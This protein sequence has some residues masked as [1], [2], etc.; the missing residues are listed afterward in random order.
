MAPTTRRQRKHI[1]IA[2]DCFLPRWDGIARFLLEIVPKLAVR[3]RITLLVP[4]F[5]GPKISLPS[6]R[7]VYIPLSSFRSGDYPVPRIEWGKI[8]NV[9][10]EA[11]LVFSQTIGPVGMLAILA[12]KQGRKPLLCYTHSV[13]WELFSNSAKYARSLIHAGTRLFCRFL[14]G[15]A[16][17]LLVPSKDT[18]AKLS[19]NG[20][21]VP[22][23]I[24]HL[25][26]NS[27]HFVPPKSKRAA[28]QAIH[29]APETILVGFSGRVAR[30]KDLP[31]LDRAFQLVKRQ[32]PR[33]RLLI[34]GKGLP[35]EKVFQSTDDIIHV[36]QTSDIQHYLQAMDVYVMPS[37]T[38]T[39]SLS[40]LEAM[41][42]GVPVIATYVGHIK[43]YI[44]H[45]KN[46]LFF[47]KQDF[48]ELAAG[49]SRL[50][51]SEKLRQEIGREGRKTVLDKYSWEKT[52]KGIVKI[53]DE[54]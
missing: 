5:P 39:S 52:V 45:G 28:K 25:G 19:R 38:E 48:R 23:R 43:H 14:Y 40:T 18:A 35:L 12:A 49:L 44:V 7:T 53:V 37:L 8:R 34:I 31:T 26:V 1:V 11:D 51:K 10:Q 9:V 21:T 27:S 30:E 22:K 2:S 50:L 13:E 6:V 3:Y 47:H 4:D 16:D 24:V 33:A 41:S 36:P 54:V 29:V 17:M 46:G 42:C 32:Y 15:K 20:I